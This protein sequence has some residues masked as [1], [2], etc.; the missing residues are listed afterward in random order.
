MR[1]ATTIRLPFLAKFRALVNKVLPN[2][3]KL[4]PL[5]PVKAQPQIPCYISFDP[6]TCIE[7]P[8]RSDSLRGQENQF[9]LPF[10][11]LHRT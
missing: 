8:V 1:V 9:K 2:L 3:Q 4:A 7:L 11:Y 5:R 10:R 6:L